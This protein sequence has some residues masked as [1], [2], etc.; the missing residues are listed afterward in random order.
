MSSQET[1]IQRLRISGLLLIAGLVIETFSLLWSHPIA[2]L[3]FLLLGGALMAAGIL[4]YLYSWVFTP[5]LS[6]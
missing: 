1:G 4:V 6:R 3:I 5:P 2:F